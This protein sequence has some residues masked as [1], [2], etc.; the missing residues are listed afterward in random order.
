MQSSLKKAPLYNGKGVY[1]ILEFA[2]DF[3]VNSVTLSFSKEIN[4]LLSSI[5]R[6]SVL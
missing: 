3:S 4:S 5:G 6:A 1:V 2:L